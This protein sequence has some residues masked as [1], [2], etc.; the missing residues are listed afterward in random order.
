MLVLLYSFSQC[1]RSS[2]VVVLVLLLLLLLLLPLPLPLPLLLLLVLLLLLLTGVKVVR[3]KNQTGEGA[4]SA[5]VYSED[6][7][8]WV[9]VVLC[10]VV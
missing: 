10:S 9:C 5:V 2:A 1:C 4:H 7:R 8:E 6:G 3:Y